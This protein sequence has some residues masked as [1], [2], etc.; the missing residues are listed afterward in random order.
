MIQTLHFFEAVGLLAWAGFIIAMLVIG[1]QVEDA[2]RNWGTRRSDRHWVRTTLTRII[3]TALA[4]GISFY[5]AG[6]ASVA[7]TEKQ[8]E[9]DVAQSTANAALGAAKTATVKVNKASD[10][11]KALQDAN[12]S[13]A[14]VSSNALT[15]ATNADK[16]SKAIAADVV[17]LSTDTQRRLAQA[18][19]VA[20]A[21]ATAAAGSRDVAQKAAE[22]A[23]ESQRA[24]VAAAVQSGVYRLPD[25]TVAAISRALAGLPRA[26]SA[27]VTCVPVLK[28][29]CAQL[30]SAFA[31]VGLSPQV[32]ANLSL[33]T[34]YDA[35]PFV[36][37]PDN[38]AVS[39]M[40]GF[41]TPARGISAALIGAN[42]RVRLESMSPN[43]TAPNLE[44]VVY[45][46]GSAP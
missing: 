19:Q 12:T 9:L 30:H 11:I 6:S 41:E 33:W 14:T 37:L 22:S 2:W 43:T 18:D 21:S 20:R 16:K 7:A 1:A 17:Q 45:Y 25:Q 3:G 24:A 36:T 26:T 29:L 27:Y 39:Y 32:N 34:G 13:L 8:K 10:T 28:D 35:N 5:A 15:L 23:R 40:V 44:I 42:L 46:A 4:A 31:A 38:V